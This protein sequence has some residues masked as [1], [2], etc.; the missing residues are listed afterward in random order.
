MTKL[1]IGIIGLGIGRHHIRGY[2]SHPNAEV[3]AIA[4]L[5]ETRLKTS[6]DEYKIA[7]RY[8]DA[9]E[10]LTQEKLDIVSVCTPNKFHKPLTLAAFKAGCRSFGGNR[11]WGVC[12][13]TTRT[14]RDH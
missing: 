3:V 13:A 14:S 4:D 5:D 9:Q 11:S 6:G 7:H 1:R 10:M 8:R 12:L 2:Q